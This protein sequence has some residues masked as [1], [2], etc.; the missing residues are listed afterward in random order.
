MFPRKVG[1][2]NEQLVSKWCSEIFEVLA[3]QRPHGSL[4]N[5]FDQVVSINK[6]LLI[7]NVLSL[8]DL[9]MVKLEI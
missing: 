3:V 1:I 7:L 5:L 9:D 8:P 6:K 2:L 4:A